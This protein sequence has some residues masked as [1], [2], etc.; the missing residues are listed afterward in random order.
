MLSIIVSFL[1]LNDK[2]KMF[3]RCTLPVTRLAR[4]NVFPETPVYQLRVSQSTD[5]RIA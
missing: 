3:P 1:L 2:K 4:A 5:R